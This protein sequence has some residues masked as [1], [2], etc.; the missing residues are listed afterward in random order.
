MDWAAQMLGLS[1]AF[2]D[3]SGAGGGVIMVRTSLIY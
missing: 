3:S 1:T 2:L